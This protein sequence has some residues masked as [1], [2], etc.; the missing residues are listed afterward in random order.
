MSISYFTVINIFLLWA[1]IIGLL[2]YI[3]LQNQ[4]DDNTND[5]SSS[6]SSD[7]TPVGTII[8]SVLNEAPPGYL[9][10]DGSNVPESSTLYKIMQKTPNLSNQFL[11]GWD[12]KTTNLLDSVANTTAVN[13]LSIDDHSHLFASYSGPGGSGQPG[14]GDIFYASQ[15]SYSTAVGV[16]PVASPGDATKPAIQAQSLTIRGDDETAPDHVIIAFYI[17]Y[18]Q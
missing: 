11:R 6:S 8:A 10:C 14:G 7:S 9:L 16:R 15:S 2:I 13:N 12:Y 1:G 3:I 5:S 4:K 17:K 18:T